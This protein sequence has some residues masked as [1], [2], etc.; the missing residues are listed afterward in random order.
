MTK[1][2]P[3]KCPWCTNPIYSKVIDNVIICPTCGTLQARNG[4]V[5]IVEYDAGAFTKALDGEKVYLPFWKLGTSYNIKSEKVA[6][7]LLGKL[8]GSAGRAGEGSLNMMLPAFDLEPQKFKEI[9]KTLTLQNP[10]Y[11][12][13]PLEP[14]VRREKCTVTIRMTDEMADFVFVTIEAEKAGVLQELAYDLKVNSKK[15]V[16]LPYYKKGNDLVPGY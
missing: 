5:S 9:A 6:G 3:I 4:I 7:G 15:L 16:Y 13:A 2:V 10:A 8:T 1:L 14:S 12:P 11:S